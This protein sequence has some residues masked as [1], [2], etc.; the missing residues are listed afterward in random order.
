MPGQDSLTACMHH[1]AH[2]LC[3]ERKGIINQMRQLEAEFATR[4]EQFH[5]QALSCWRAQTAY[6]EAAKDTVETRKYNQSYI[7]S[8]A[9]A[10]MRDDL[11]TEQR[12]YDALRGRMADTE[13]EPDEKK[14]KGGKEKEKE[15]GPDV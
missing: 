11:R 6:F 10:A 1:T 8:K 15:S 7:D 3:G 9:N 12:S 4:R 2:H 13:K 14:G 5:A